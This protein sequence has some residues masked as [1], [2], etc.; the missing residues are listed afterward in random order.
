MHPPVRV[1]HL[2][3][4]VVHETMLSGPHARGPTQTSERTQV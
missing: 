4:R 3:M 2:G 1:Y